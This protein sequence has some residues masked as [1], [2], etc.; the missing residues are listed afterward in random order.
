MSPGLRASTTDVEPVVPRHARG[1]WHAYGVRTVA[2]CVPC[3]PVARRQA[4]LRFWCTCVHQGG[5]GAW[6]GGRYRTRSPFTYQHGG[7]WEG[8]PWDVRV[9]LGGT[10][11]RIYIYRLDA[12]ENERRK[13]HVNVE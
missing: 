10:R 3:R 5:A 8:G 12:N 2:M 11:K 9:S 13:T 4:A 6:A 1:S 7:P